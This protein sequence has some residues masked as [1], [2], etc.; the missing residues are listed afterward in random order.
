MNIFNYKNNNCISI[1][2]KDYF[3]LRAYRLNYN[4]LIFLQVTGSTPLHKED[5]PEKNW[6]IITTK[7][8]GTRVYTAYKKP[9][10]SYNLNNGI[11]KLAFVSATI[12]GSYFLTLKFIA[13]KFNINLSNKELYSLAKKYEKEELFNYQLNKLNDEGNTDESMILFD[14]GYSFEK[15]DALKLLDLEGGD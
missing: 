15:D 7:S 8:N 11:K 2:G 14:P 13:K 3:L 12:T 9:Y 5:M 1:N 4:S 6:E 10:F